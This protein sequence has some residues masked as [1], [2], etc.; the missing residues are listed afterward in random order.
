MRDIITQLLTDRKTELEEAFTDE[1]GSDAPLDAVLPFSYTSAETGI[2][3]GV[4][5]P[6]LVLTVGKG[7]LVDDRISG[8][9]PLEV[10]GNIVIADE[11]GDQRRF[12]AEDIQVIGTVYDLYDFDYNGQDAWAVRDAAIMEAGFGTIGTGGHIFETWVNL[13][14]P[15]IATISL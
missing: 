13:D 10:R 2:T 11:D 4:A 8:T 14:T 9:R 5:D 7:T 3:F 15:F 1:Y 12:A 6:D